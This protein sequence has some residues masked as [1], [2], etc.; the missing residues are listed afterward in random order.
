MNKTEKEKM[1]SGDFYFANDPELVIERKKA[2]TLCHRYNQQVQDLDEQTLAQILGYA[3]DAYIEPPFYCD[4]GYN[5]RF[6]KKVYANHNLVILDGAQVTIGN[7]V[8]IG[9]NVVISTA[10]HP[11]DVSIRNSE[12]EFAKP[13]QIEDNV[14]IGANVVILP[15]IQIG[16]NVTIGASSIV[17]KSIESDCVAVGNPCRVIRRLN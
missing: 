4:Y 12:L 5:I 1:L 14:W 7:H 9:P 11:T 15:G 10:G 13:I 2:K 6:G 17:T 16:A 3:S 8:F